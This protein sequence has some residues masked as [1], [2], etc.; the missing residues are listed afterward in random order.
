MLELTEQ[1]DRERAEKGVRG[2]LHRP[3]SRTVIALIWVLYPTKS[4]EN[5]LS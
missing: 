1:A 3:F 4:D 2:P 5:R